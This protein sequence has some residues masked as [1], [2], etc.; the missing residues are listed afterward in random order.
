MNLAKIASNCKCLLSILLFLLKV[1]VSGVLDCY[2]NE[3]YLR[4]I[5]VIS[6]IEIHKQVAVSQKHRFRMTNGEL[7]HL[8]PCVLHDRLCPYLR[9]AF[10]LENFKRRSKSTPTID[11]EPQT[12][13][14]IIRAV[15]VNGYHAPVRQLCWRTGLCF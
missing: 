4:T 15:K 13:Y 11:S 2:P 10:Q 12:Y 3:I 7:R 5:L 6:N 14:R 1:K 9:S 8:I